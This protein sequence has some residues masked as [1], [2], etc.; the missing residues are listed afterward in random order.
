MPFVE[1]RDITLYYKD[2]G[3]GDPP[4]LLLHELGGSGDSWGQIIPLITP[5]RRVIAPDMRCAGRS[6]K[7]VR[8]FE[9]TDVG[10]DITALLDSLGIGSIDVV[11]AALGA[12]VAAV[13]AS[14]APQRV[15]RMVLCAVTDVIDRRTRDYLNERA[16]HLRTAGMRGVVDASLANAFPQ[17]HAAARARYRPIYLA[18]DPA[19][20]A[21]LSKALA[22]MSTTPDLWRHVRCPTL[23]MSGRHDFIW[24]PELGRRVADQLPHAAFLEL[25]DAGHF[26]HL[27][28]PEAL[29]D[30][31]L[32]FLSRTSL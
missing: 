16:G 7:P 22:E 3:T 1:L 18:N 19:G 10:D 24:P 9:I 25:V 23:V 30:A 20:Y 27:Q 15:R 14:Q 2:A 8:G 17:R 5:H 21:A 28:T 4:V 29:A 26:P 12:M 32:P 11:G 6:E 13:M 31:A